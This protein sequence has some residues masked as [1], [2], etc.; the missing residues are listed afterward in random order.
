VATLGEQRVGVRDD[1]PDHALAS[2]V[3]VAAAAVR[4][5]EH[6]GVRSGFRVRLPVAE[7]LVAQPRKDVDEADAG[8][9]LQVLD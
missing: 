8:L 6:E 5:R 4:S 2:V 3:L 7:K 9:G 1:R